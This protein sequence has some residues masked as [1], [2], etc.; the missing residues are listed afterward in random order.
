MLEIGLKYI[1]EKTIKENESAKNIGSGD[2]EVFSTPSLI[3]FMENCAM[4]CI[5]N[6][7]NEEDTTVGISINM[8][9]LQANLIGEKV[10]GEATLINIDGRKLTFEITVTSDRGEIGKATHERFIVNR[11]KFINKL[12]NF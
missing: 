3:A 4:N 12:K 6:H 11:E 2:L 1:Q 5:K 7:I 9:H 8:K 10:K